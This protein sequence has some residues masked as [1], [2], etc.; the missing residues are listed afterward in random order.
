MN[1]SIYIKATSGSASNCGPEVSPPAEPDRYPPTEAGAAS[2]DAPPPPEVFRIHAAFPTRTTVQAR[3][4]GYAPDLTEKPV[5]T[6]RELDC[7][8]CN[9]NPTMSDLAGRLNPENPEACAA[10]RIIDESELL[11]DVTWLKDESSFRPISTLLRTTRSGASSLSHRQPAD[12]RE[13]LETLET[14]AVV[15]K[16]LAELNRNDTAWRAGEELPYLEAM[17]HDFERALFCGTKPRATERFHGFA[18]RYARLDA[19]KAAT[20]P[21]VIDAGGRGK[22]LTSIWLVGWSPNTCY[23]FYPKNTAAGLRIEDIGEESAWDKEGGEFRALKTQYTWTFGL[24]V[25]DWRYV[26][27][28]ANIPKSLVEHV[29]GE[30]RTQSTENPS[31]SISAEHPLCVLLAQALNLISSHEGVLLAFYGNRDVATVLNLLRAE[32]QNTCLSGKKTES[33]PGVLFVNGIPF[34][35]V[36]ALTWGEKEVW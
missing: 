6:S 14:I 2:R 34:R 9:T 22:N 17:S 28:I 33:R 20:A 3:V 27:R 15:D 30:C 21:N 24:S 29:A 5:Q 31:P 26:V 32:P 19:K 16:K 10:C 36:D 8:T 1:Q 35:R 12:R 11:R 7:M 18:G 23:C 25:R 13:T 4:A